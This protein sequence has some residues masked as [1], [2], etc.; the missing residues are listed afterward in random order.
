METQEGS[1]WASF[2]SKSLGSHKDAVL[3]VLVM[4]LEGREYVLRQSCA[5]LALWMIVWLGAETGLVF[6]LMMRVRRSGAL[7]VVFSHMSMACLLQ[8]PFHFFTCLLML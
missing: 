7:R 5:D 2:S 8:G 3:A 4:C 6:Y 1:L